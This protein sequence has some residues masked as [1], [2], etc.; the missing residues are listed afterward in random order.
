MVVEEHLLDRRVECDLLELAEPRSARDLDDDQPADRV[1]LETAHL[2]DRPQLVRVQPIEVT[3]VP[4]QRA[5]GDDGAREERRAA[6]MAPNASK[7]VFPCVA[8]TC[9]ARIVRI[10]ARARQAAE[11]GARPLRTQP[12]TRASGSVSRCRNSRARIPAL[13][14]ARDVCH[15]L[16]FHERA[17]RKPGDLNGRAG[18]RA[19]ADVPGIH[20]VHPREVAQVHEEHG[21]LDESVQATP[22]PPRGWPRGSP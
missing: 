8:M 16:D 22:P 21:G 19:I 11:T 6:S 7:S 9:S 18:R 2:C 20:P 10:V 1:E 12:C 3:N 5:D 14:K 17:A 4:V 15:C 13:R